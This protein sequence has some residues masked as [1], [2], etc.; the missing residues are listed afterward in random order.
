MYNYFT[1]IS[2]NVA[3][4]SYATKYIVKFTLKKIDT[5]RSLVYEIKNTTPRSYVP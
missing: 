4:V 1:G 2:M 3:I 5:I